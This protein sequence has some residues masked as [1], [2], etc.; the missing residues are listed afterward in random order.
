[1]TEAQEAKPSHADA[2]KTFPCFMTTNIALAKAS[3]MAK[4]NAKVVGNCT[5]PTL[6]GCPAQLPG[7]GRRCVV[8]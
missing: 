8:L 5:L 7:K 1:M 2:L 4:P 6:V 3:P